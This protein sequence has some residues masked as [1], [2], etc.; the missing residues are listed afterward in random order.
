MIN[1]S[2]GRFVTANPIASKTQLFTCSTGDVISGGTITGRIIDRLGLGTRAQFRAAHVGLNVWTTVGATSTSFD[3]K[4]ALFVALQHGDS[5]GG[6]DMAAYSSGLTAAVKTYGTTQLTT[7]FAQW[8]TAPLAIDHASYYE[9]TSAKQFIRV[10]AS[11][12]RLGIATATAI[13]L[14][15]AYAD[16]S[17]YLC[18]TDTVPFDNDMT[19][20]STST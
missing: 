16:L 10:V 6:G 4:H 12:T 11:W 1:R 3:R 2:R 8:S 14:D 7:S 20:T 15:Q 13:G 18:E 9:I 17:C 19:S 5:S